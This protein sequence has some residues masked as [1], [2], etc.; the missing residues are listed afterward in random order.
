MLCFALSFSGETEELEAALAVDQSDEGAARSDDRPR[1]FALG[2][3]TAD[4]V[5]AV[6]VK[7][8]P[9]PYN[10]TPTTSTT[11]MLALGE[12]ARHWR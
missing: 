9:C 4:V 5:I 3:R 1:P 11:A 10:L 2:A 12:R 8:E 6:S 7:R